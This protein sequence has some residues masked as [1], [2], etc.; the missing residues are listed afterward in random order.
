MQKLKAAFIA[1]FLI[2]ALPVHK[3]YSENIFKTFKFD[4]ENALNEWKEKIFKNKVFYNVKP[5]QSGGFL[6]AESIRSCSGL[7]YKIRFNPRIYPMI[8][9]KWKVIKFPNKNKTKSSEGGW[10]EKDDYSARVYVIFPSISFKNTKCIEYVWDEN[11]PEGT[12]MTSPYMKNIKIIV[13][14]SGKENINNWVHEER[15]IPE[16]YINAFGKNPPHVGAIA[17]MTDADNT[18]STAEALYAEIKVRYKNE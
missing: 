18:L 1:I 4:K 15:N 8:S 9:W 6:S 11:L 17:L 2:L 10:L 14:E 12:I 16:D 13:I 5:N 3:S 7:F